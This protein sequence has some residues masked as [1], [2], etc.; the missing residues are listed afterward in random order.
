MYPARPAVTNATTTPIPGLNRT[1]ISI[2]NMAAGKRYGNTVRPGT[3][4]C[5]TIVST[6][7]LEARMAAKRALWISRGCTRSPNSTRTVASVV[8][9]KV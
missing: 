4:A 5:M 9:S 6:T 8:T 2:G 7:R 3:M 1:A